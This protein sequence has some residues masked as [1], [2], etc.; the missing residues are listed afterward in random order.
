[1]TT[2]YAGITIAELRASP[3]RILKRAKDEDHAVAILSRNKPAGYLLSP[4]LM[5][6]MLDAVADRIAETRAKSR[7]TTLSTARKVKLD[8]L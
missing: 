5:D 1:M 3:T 4:K 7:L 2:V 8:D 6:A